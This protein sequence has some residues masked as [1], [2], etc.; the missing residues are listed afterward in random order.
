ML[1]PLDLSP[2][3]AVVVLLIAAQLVKRSHRGSLV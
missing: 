3:V 1:G 2:V